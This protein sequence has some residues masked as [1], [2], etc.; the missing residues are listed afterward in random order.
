MLSLSLLCAIVETHSPTICLCVVH[1]C[2]WKQSEG[3][4]SEAKQATL[5]M[6]SWVV[7]KLHVSWQTY[8]LR[9]PQISVP[10]VYRHGENCCRRLLPLPLLGSF[11]GRR[12]LQQLYRAKLKSPQIILFRRSRDM[13]RT[14]VLVDVSFSFSFSSSSSS[15]SCSLGTV[16]VNCVEKTKTNHAAAR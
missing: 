7:Q 15:S 2:V 5:L 16:G 11:V 9:S 4:A 8:C 1:L 3:G 13:E 10:E 12:V 14:V 6:F